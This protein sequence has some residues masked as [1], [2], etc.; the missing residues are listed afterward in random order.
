MKALALDA[1]T[2]CLTVAARN[3]VHTVT[4]SLDVG[5]RQSE[6][7]LP[8]IDYVLSQVELSVGNL[9]YTALCRGPGAFT[10]LRLSFSAL[11]AIELAHGVP[12]Y[13]ID[14]LA[15]FAFPYKNFPNKVVSVVDAKKGQFFAAVYQNEKT[16]L[17]AQDTTVETVL[18]FLEAREMVI[19]AG[20]DATVFADALKAKCNTLNIVCLESKMIATDA[21]FLLTEEAIEKNIPPL[22]EY[23]GPAYLRKSEAERLLERQ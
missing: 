10:G 23:E 18:S 16:L 5:T 6:K 21:L 15:A 22:C 20:P 3:G 9:D 4:L 7:L 14:S 13:G 19:T 2:S 12:I 8:A 17:E 11:K 1:A